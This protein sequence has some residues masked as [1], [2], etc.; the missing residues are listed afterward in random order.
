[1]SLGRTH[2]G[3][4][5]LAAVAAACGARTGDEALDANG[6]IIGAGGSTSGSGG[7]GGTNVGGSSVGGSSGTRG[8]A[9]GTGGSSCVPPGCNCQDCYST[10]L[11][12]TS[13]QKSCAQ[14]CGLAGGAGGSTGFGGDAGFGGTGGFPGNCCYSHSFAG[15]D[16]PFITQCVCSV[17]AFCCTSTWDAT[18]TN[19]VQQ[20]GCG[21]CGIA[22]AGGSSFGGAGGVAGS[23]AFGG[24]G[25]FGGTAGMPGVICGGQLC[26]PVA[27]PIQSL[28]PCCPSNNPLICGADVSPFAGLIPLPPGCL[29]LH[30]PGVADP[31]CP[32]YFVQAA[33]ISLP[34]C[35]KPGGLCGVDFD[36]IQ[37]GCVDVSQSGGPS[38]RACGF[39]GAG[40]SAGAGG[41]AGAGGS[42]GFGAIAGTG[43]IAGSGG[44]GGSAGSAGA[45]GAGGSGG[46]TMECCVAHPSPNCAQP[47]V[48]ACVCAADPFCCTTRWDPL[49]VSEIDQ[50]H[51]GTCS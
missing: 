32:A 4:L 1:M 40:G 21:F 6:N 24:A 19:E 9:G 38:P 29:A 44:V 10:C 28:A 23:G 51:C 39:A 5:F 30:Q 7:L 2:L 41:T 36:I 46:T 8:G 12:Q 33:G 22:G 43:G 16:D 17:D 35:C 31:T 20:A 15:C 34:G 11:C 14:A 47:D 48:A 42:G 45:S 27:T 37:L 25:G 18:C 49:C 50:L 26:Q 3:A 13:G